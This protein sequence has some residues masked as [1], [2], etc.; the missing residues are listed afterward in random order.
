MDDDFETLGAAEWVGGASF[1]PQARVDCLPLVMFSIVGE[2]GLHEEDVALAI[3]DAFDRLVA[4]AP[5]CPDDPTAAEGFYAIVL[6]QHLTH[7]AGGD[8]WRRCVGS[9]RSTSRPGRNGRVMTDQ[10][11]ERLK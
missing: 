8:P 2:W 10:L 1:E 6:A 7:L 9:T 4:T 3:P 11:R 5:R